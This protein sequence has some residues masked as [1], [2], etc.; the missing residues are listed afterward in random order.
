[1]YPLLIKNRI[2]KYI[3]SPI[4][5]I[6]L[7]AFDLLILNVLRS[8][9]SMKTSSKFLKS[10]R[11]RYRVVKYGTAKYVQLNILRSPSVMY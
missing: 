6:W 9:D 3:E 2:I 5:P 10:S 4:A 11:K 8:K 7:A 1:M